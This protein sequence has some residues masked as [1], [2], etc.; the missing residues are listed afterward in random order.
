MFSKHKKSPRLLALILLAGVVSIYPVNAEQLDKLIW[1]D[2]NLDWDEQLPSPI[3]MGGRVLDAPA[4]KHGR[5]RAVGEKLVFE[6]GTPFKLWGA[7]IA[8]SNSIGGNA[9]PPPKKDAAKL[10]D[11]IA[12]YGF[13][14]IRFIGFDGNAEQAIQNWHKNGVIKSELL[15]RLDYLVKE[16][17]ERGIYYSFSINNNSSKLF[18][19]TN[20][21]EPN[22]KEQPY[23]HYRTLRVIDE[24]GRTKVAEWSREFLAHYNPYTQQTYAEDNA[25][26]YFNAVN[27]D[28]SVLT[29]YTRLRK[30]SP[31]WAEKIEKQFADF[32]KQKYKTNDALREA[33]LQS[34]KVG[35]ESTEDIDDGS[36]ALRPLTRI[37]LMSSAR[38]S[39]TSE[40]LISLD[41]AIAEAVSS[42][43]KSVGYD[44]LYTGNNKWM[45][46]SSLYASYLH[47]NYIEGHI[48]YGG[49]RYI[50]DKKTNK[51]TKDLLVTNRSYIKEMTAGEKSLRPLFNDT[52]FGISRLLPTNLVDR[53]FIASEW[54][55]VIWSDYAYEGLFIMLGLGSRMGVDGLDM[56]LY[57]N[58]PGPDYKTT[59]AESSYTITGSPL[60]LALLPSM[61]LA[62]QKDY[63]EQA[64]IRAVYCHAKDKN[65]LYQ[66]GL[67]R[68]EIKQDFETVIMRHGIEYV[69]AA[70]GEGCD[71]K[72]ERGNNRM[73]AVVE[74][75]SY[76]NG[77]FNIYTKKFEAL[78]GDLIN[79]QNKGGVLSVNLSQQGSLSA[80]SLDDQPLTE[81]LCILTTVGGPIKNSKAYF[82]YDKDGKKS[83]HSMTK[84]EPQIRANT[85]EIQLRLNKLSTASRIAYSIR[86]DGSKT[87]LDNAVIA[88]GDKEIVSLTAESLDSPWVLVGAP[89][90]VS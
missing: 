69:R 88:N 51:R 85:G 32:L 1:L 54:N 10:A 47:G 76:K 50:V 27:E 14:H 43:V 90:C 56:Q 61:A 89:S 55:H 30:F 77:H 52:R 35:L 13:N 60:H 58:S 3:A 53:P 8:F 64:E 18:R 25:N 62:F 39:D 37:T 5:L 84:G 31:E 28:T 17:Q 19:D 23:K 21:L 59:T 11:K 7:G 67:L 71:F 66:K 12:S 87:R 80:I 36:V 86:A 41:I 45:G 81:S 38:I 6:D 82:S 75:V 49:G 68:P 20:I 40:F 9:V 74:P 26:I 34:G 72:P 15:D 29:Y 33:W 65:E 73:A 16:L 22:V 83:I 57:F 42:S 79:N 4:G 63:I 70:I 2:F 48:Y 46:Y 78:V 44:R 24:A